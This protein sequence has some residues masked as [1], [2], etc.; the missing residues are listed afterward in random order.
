MSS[1]IFKCLLI[2]LSTHMCFIPIVRTDVAAREVCI[3]TKNANKKNRYEERKTFVDD[4]WNVY[5]DEWCYLLV[6]QLT[7]FFVHY[8]H[9]HRSLWY[10]DGG[11]LAGF[12]VY[13]SCMAWGSDWQLFDQGI[14]VKWQIKAF[15]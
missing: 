11:I 12:I 8:E 1:S 3:M 9:H 4:N 2:S 7:K 14:E 10:F 6:H 15:P 13:I 5:E